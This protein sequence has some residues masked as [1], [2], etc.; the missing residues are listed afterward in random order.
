MGLLKANIALALQ[1]PEMASD[2][3]EFLSETLETLFD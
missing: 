1:R 3:R 2:L